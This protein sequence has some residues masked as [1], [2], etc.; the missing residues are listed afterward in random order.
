[1]SLGRYADLSGNR[2]GRLVAVEYV[3]HNARRVAL[4]RC[5]CDCG[6]EKVI[7]AISLKRGESRSCGCLYKETRKGNYQIQHGKTGQRIYR[8]W[9]AMKSR[10][11]NPNRKYYE[12][13]G[14]RGISV[15]KEWKDDFGSFYEWAKNNGYSDSLTIDRI[16]GNGN[17]EP[18]NCRWVSMKE[19]AKNRRMRRAK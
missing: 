18:N 1:M 17:Y 9:S 19:Q 8:I 16:E 13:Y 15:C 4:W 12:N 3:G 7:P 5:K 2:F 14:G 10:C 11:S 6:K